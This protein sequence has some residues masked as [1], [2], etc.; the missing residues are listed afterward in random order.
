MFPNMAARPTL[1]ATSAENGSSVQ[2][3]LPCKSNGRKFVYSHD[4]MMDIRERGGRLVDWYLTDRLEKLGLLHRSYTED[5]PVSSGDLTEKKYRRR[6]CDR[7]RK[8]GKRA[9]VRANPNNPAIPSVLLANVRSLDDK[10]DDLR[11]W[12]SMQRE[13]RDCSVYIFSE[14]WLTDKIPDSGVE[15][16]GLTLH[17]ADRVMSSTG[18]LRGGGWAVYTKNSWCSDA[19]V[20]LKS[21]SPDAEQMV[22]KCRPF[23]L[24]N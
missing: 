9:G 19:R 5:S 15:L 11:L 16:E 8:R 1:A 7:T 6:R 4:F 13:V 24:P 23:Y 3:L 21:C 14:T 2:Q 18:K 22:V 20:I 17:R 12:R 10:M